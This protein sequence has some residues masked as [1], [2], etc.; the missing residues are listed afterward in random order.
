M[1]T[2]KTYRIILW[3]TGYTY[4]RRINYYKALERLG[5]IKICGVISDASWDG[6]PCM[7]PEEALRAEPDYILYTDMQQKKEIVAQYTALTGGRREKLIPADAL[8]YPGMT[9]QRYAEIERRKPTILSNTC[10]GGVLTGLLGLECRSP[11]KNMWIPEH[12]YLWILEE[13]RKYFSMT[14]EFLRWEEGHAVYEEKKYP[15]LQL[16]NVQLYCNH[17]TD[18]EAAIEE[19]RRR[20]AKVN[21]DYMIAQYHTVSRKNEKKFSEL[22]GYVKKICFV[23]HETDLPDSVGLREGSVLDLLNDMNG[24]TLPLE[25]H[26]DVSALL[27]GED[28]VWRSDRRG[29]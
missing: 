24:L 16:G 2:D 21:Y 7:T 11:L 18:P 17:T 27:L 4:H 28:S 19:F 14:P 1:T 3:G 15:V 13:P 22:T 26:M 6:Y 29:R 20:A 25:S 8:M 9:F 10:W 23:N 5:E 12:Q